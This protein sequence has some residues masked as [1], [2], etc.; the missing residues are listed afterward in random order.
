M[1]A[2]PISLS[3]T[4]RAN[5]LAIAFVALAWPAPAQYNQPAEDKPTPGIY[6]PPNEQHP[7]VAL[8]ILRKSNHGV[9]ISVGSERSFIGAAL[10][11]AVALY[12]IDY[13]ADTI[14]FAV[15]NRALLAASTSREDYLTLRLT[16]PAD[17]W[18]KR[19]E[20][21]SAEDRKTLAN[22][23]SWSFWQQA[24][25]NNLSAWDEAFLHFHTKPTAPTDP[26]FASNY[27]FDDALYTHLSH[28]AKTSRIWARVLDLRHENEIRAL[29]LDVKSKALTFGAPLIFGVIDTSDMPNS[30]SGGRSV[31]AHYIKYFSQYAQPDTLFL[32]TAPVGGGHGVNWSYYAFRNSTLH[33][34]D[35][36]VIQR[37]FDIEMKKINTTDQPH[38]FLDD[39]DAITH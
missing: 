28:L 20:R 15:I 18:L 26:F 37:W 8:P 5:L 25:R 1:E 36:L 14:H 16:A 21:L 13:D 3:S 19:S 31:V 38:S 32:N 34:R 7:A 24:I 6:I 11:R 39:P 27:L 10:T 4:I 29:C 2:I 17:I 33:G 22:P 9:Y 35:P 23:A 12:V 30:P